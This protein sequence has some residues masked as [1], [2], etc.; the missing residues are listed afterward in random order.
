MKGSDLWLVMVHMH[1]FVIVK[2]YCYDH[3]MHQFGLHQHIYVDVDT[4]DNMYDVNNRGK[5][6]DDWLVVHAQYVNLWH[7]WRDHVFTALYPPIDLDIYMNI[8][9]RFI[10]LPCVTRCPR[11]TLRQPTCNPYNYETRAPRYNILL[12]ME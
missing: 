2:V 11:D 10:T 4:F 6:E 1:C 7:A 3:E 9:K 5:E 12:C 8:I